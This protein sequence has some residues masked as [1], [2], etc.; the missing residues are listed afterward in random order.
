MNLL[1]KICDA[2]DI[3]IEKFILISKYAINKIQD[4]IIQK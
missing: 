3:S 2:I 1:L 4:L